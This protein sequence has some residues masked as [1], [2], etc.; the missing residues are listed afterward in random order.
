MKLYIFARVKIVYVRAMAIECCCI[1]SR[2]LWQVA[3]TEI[4]SHLFS[5]L[6]SVEWVWVYVWKRLG[7]SLAI[8]SNPTIL[9][10]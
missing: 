8:Y 1:E 6:S 5:I 4:I 10:P 2:C 3:F 7:Y 9:L